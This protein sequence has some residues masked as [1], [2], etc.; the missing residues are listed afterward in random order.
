MVLW[1]SGLDLCT[2]GLLLSGRIYFSATIRSNKLGL[3]GL[4]KHNQQ[5]NVKHYMGQDGSRQSISPHDRGKM[6][7][8]LILL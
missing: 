6:D 1:Q 8:G 3:L 7:P 2:V 4:H 5:T